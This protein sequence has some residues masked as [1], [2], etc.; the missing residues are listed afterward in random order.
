MSEITR[1]IRVFHVLEGD[2]LQIKSTPYGDIGNLYGD[3]RIEAVWVRKQ[4]E[5]IDPEW[6]SQPSVDLILVMQGQLK[7]EFEGRTKDRLLRQGDFLVLPKDTRCKAYHWPR[8]SE[9]AAIFL[10]V[11]PMEPEQKSSI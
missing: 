7:V 2:A 5:A 4:D 3:E 8:E 10:A 9:K 6:F 1:R 11:Y